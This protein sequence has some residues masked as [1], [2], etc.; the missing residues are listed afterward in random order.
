MVMMFEWRYV[1]IDV[2]GYIHLFN[3]VLVCQI[4]V[5]MAVIMFA[6]VMN[7]HIG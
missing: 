5:M 6:G 2:R 1:S 7:D 4:R 3:H